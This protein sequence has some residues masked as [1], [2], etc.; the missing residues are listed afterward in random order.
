MWSRRK[1]S[2][3][4][5]KLSSIA[6]DVELIGI[7]SSLRW[8]WWWSSS[9]FNRY[10]QILNG[11]IGF[12]VFRPIVEM[13][14]FDKREYYSIQSIYEHSI[15]KHFIHYSSESKHRTVN[16]SLVESYVLI[17]AAVLFSSISKNSSILTVWQVILYKLI[18]LV[19]IAE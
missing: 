16:L 4:C 17:W 15:I 5:R 1:H 11:C 6:Q 18:Q 12:R 8:W 14:M 10:E 9:Y 13:T 7:G 19:T 2:V 3:G